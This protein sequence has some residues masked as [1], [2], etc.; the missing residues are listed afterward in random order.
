MVSILFS[1]L[2]FTC[3]LLAPMFS[4]NPKEYM[5]PI[6]SVLISI[7]LMHCQRIR[8]LGLV[9]IGGIFHMNLSSAEL[10]FPSFLFLG[11]SLAFLILSVGFAIHADCTEGKQQII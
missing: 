4:G 7:P 8:S 10:L 2:A 11:S 6:V 3:V 1:S 9:G 5:L